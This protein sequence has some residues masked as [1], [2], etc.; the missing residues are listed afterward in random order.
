MSW[1]SLD[2]QGRGGPRGVYRLAVEPHQSGASKAGFHLFTPAQ[3]LAAPVAGRTVVPVLIDRAGYEGRVELSAEGLPAGVRLEGADI[4]E[5]AD[6]ALVTVQRGD[7][8]NGAVITRWLGRTAEGEDRPVTIKDHPLERLQPW[9]ATE[10]A[11]ATTA[12]KG[13]DFQVDW[14]GLPAD[15]GLVPASKLTLPVKVTKPAGSGAVR[16]TLLTSQVRPIVN[17]RLDP[18]QTLRLEKAVELPAAST[19]GNLVLLVPPQP[20]SP[21]YDVTVLAELLAPDKK[22]LQTAYAPVRRMTVRHQV[23][24]RLAGPSRI[25]TTPNPKTGATV[26]VEGQI[27]RRE[28]LTSAVV[29]T[30]TGLPGGGR[31]APA[32]VKAGTTAFAL[33]VVLPPGVAPGEITGLKLSATAVLDA[34]QPNIRVRSRDVDL[35]LV[36]KPAK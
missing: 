32:T 31:V 18:N 15:A 13:S 16:L 12:A 4:P 22:T 3:R 27:E 6:G 14:R 26:K 19:D 1:P 28:N 34:K 17:G 21:V 24:V 10:L 20:V 35:T 36:I 9:L 33:N 8:A 30:L 2:S 23:V 29:L 25:E 5:G 11:L 7:S